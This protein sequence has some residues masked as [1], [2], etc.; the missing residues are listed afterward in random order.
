MVVFTAV[1]YRQT[2]SSVSIEVGERKNAVC[3]VTC[4][5]PFDARCRFL[6]SVCRHRIPTGA[7]RKSAPEYSVPRWDVLCRV[8]ILTE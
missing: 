8:E 1:A 4:K 6:K 3:P 2:F 5:K 7:S